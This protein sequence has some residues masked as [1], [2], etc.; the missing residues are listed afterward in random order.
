MR[1]VKFKHS[2]EKKRKEEEPPGSPLPAFL[3]ECSTTHTPSTAFLLESKGDI[4]IS[5]QA[6]GGNR[7]FITYLL[8]IFNNPRAP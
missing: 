1:D 5:A 6:Y 2:R 4:R 7:P 3:A 8:Q